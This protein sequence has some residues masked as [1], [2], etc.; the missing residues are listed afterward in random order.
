MLLN[1]KGTTW[2]QLDPEAQQAVTG[3]A[4]AAALMLAQTSVIKRPVVEWH[5]GSATVGFEA[6]AWAA[7]MLV[8]RS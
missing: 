4:T 5:D 7:R 6:D 2:Q 1:R 3:A 8:I